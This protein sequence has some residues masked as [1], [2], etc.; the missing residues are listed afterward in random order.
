MR[1]GKDI[2]DKVNT[3]RKAKVI[4]ILV[5]VECRTYDLAARMI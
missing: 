1:S 3:K 4:A 5:G 2:E